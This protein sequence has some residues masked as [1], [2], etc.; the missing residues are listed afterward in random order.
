[1]RRAALSALLLIL[2]ICGIASGERVQRGN[3]IVRLD[4]NFAPLTLP[5][6]RQAP[7][8]VHLD[9]GLL[10]ADGSLLPRVTRVELGIPGQ[11]VITTKGLPTCTPRRIRNATTAKALEL[12]GTAL[13]GSGR[14]EA[15]VKIPHQ[16]PFVVHARLLAFNGRV[17][18]RRAVIV[19]GIS[20]RPP[21]VVALPFLIESRRGKFGTVLVARLPRTLGPWPRFAH[22]EMDLERHYVYRGNRLSYLSASCPIPRRSTAGFFSFA[23]ATFTL[24]GG[25]QISTG[26]ARSCR[27]HRA[28]S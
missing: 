8:S 21:T 17:H 2:I 15:Q 7:V 23:K 25:R 12:C 6:D 11:G 24:A 27:A 14:M 26:I 10:T 18:G 28:E 4:G 20:A 16:D 22:F 5:R 9:A 13:I 19:H 1:M 3:L